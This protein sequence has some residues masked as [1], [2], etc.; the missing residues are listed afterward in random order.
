LRQRLVSVSQISAFSI[1]LVA[2]VGAISFAVIVTRSQSV[3]I[4]KAVVVI[5]SL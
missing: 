4:F 1:L 5:E 3:D 2:L